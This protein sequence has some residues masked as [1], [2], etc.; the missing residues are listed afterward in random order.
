MFKI[1]LTSYRIS[2]SWNELI[3]FH[4]IQTEIRRIH[5]VILYCTKMFKWHAHFPAP[6]A[7]HE[8]ANGSS[9][10]CKMTEIFTDKMGIHVYQSRNELLGTFALSRK[11][12]TTFIMS[13]HPLCV[14]PPHISAWIPLD[15]LPWNLILG[16]SKKIRRHIQNFVKIWQKHQTRYM[17]T[18]VCFILAGDVKSPKSASF[19]CNGI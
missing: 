1:T 14:P 13:I 18:L 4:K 6:A 16:T 3:T 9:G 10:W 7:C 15:G 8:S 17:K 11:G 2:L 12:P 19:E 5:L